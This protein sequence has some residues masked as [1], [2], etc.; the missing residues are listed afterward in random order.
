[1]N[2]KSFR[3]S[4][5]SSYHIVL[6]RNVVNGEDIDKFLNA[7]DAKIKRLIPNEK[8][9]PKVMKWFLST[10]K[11]WVMNEAEAQAYTKHIG[12][13]APEW[14]QKASA[15]GDKLV[16]VEPKN[17]KVGKKFLPDALD[18]LIDFFGVS[19]NFAERLT[20]PVAFDKLDKWGFEKDTGISQ[21]SKLGA[22]DLEVIQKLSG[23]WSIVRLLSLAALDREG[24][25]M[26]NC[27][28]LKEAGNTYYKRIKEQGLILMSLRD[29]KG[30]PHC[31]FEITKNG[32]IHQM[33]G[34]SNGAVSDQSLSKVHEFLKQHKA[35]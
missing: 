28:K 8:I 22:D 5:T 20:V 13:D 27:M 17:V 11:K 10:L 31:N 19:G 18:H 1:M 21:K 9:Q 29:P 32:E 33:K 26:G 25:D 6:A 12:E 16:Y 23:G 34:F 2:T 24:K 4:V 7:Y 3:Q 15:R 14:L 35:L 30:K